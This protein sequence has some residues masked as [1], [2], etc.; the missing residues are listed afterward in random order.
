MALPHLEAAHQKRP[1]EPIIFVSLLRCL[2]AMGANEQALQRLETWQARQTKDNSHVC[3]MRARL[4]SDLGRSDEAFTWYKRAEQVSP[5]DEEAIRGLETLLR[6][7][8]DQEEADRYKRRG[9]DIYA[10]LNRLETL[11][12]KIRDDPDEPKWRVEAG[13]ILLSLGHEGVGVRWL[14]SVLVIDENHRDAHLALAK[15]Y[16][17][18]G[19]RGRA[20]EHRQAAEGKLKTRVRIGPR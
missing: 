19:D 6:E 7:Q 13:E 9:D 5:N 3:V 18:K 1:N 8:G 20:E 2:R 17:A 16:E 11:T 12:Q 15:Y 10:K 4:A 14:T